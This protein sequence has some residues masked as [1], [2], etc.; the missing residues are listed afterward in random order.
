TVRSEW[1][2]GRD[3]LTFVLSVPVNST[4]TVSLPAS[5]SEVVTEG[6]GGVATRGGVEGVRFLRQ[7]GE[8]Q[9]F[10]VGS[11]K[12]RFRVAASK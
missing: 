7:E 11:G 2:R 8:R 1:T 6:A 10:E 9:V 5:A 12:Y 4:A 3:G